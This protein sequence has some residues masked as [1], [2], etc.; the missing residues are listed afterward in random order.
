MSE[1]GSSL[2]D[3]G[4]ADKVGK[5]PEEKP[6]RVKRVVTGDVGDREG[7]NL[8]TMRVPLRTQ[9]GDASRRNPFSV[10]FAPF[11]REA[12]RFRNMPGENLAT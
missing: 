5:G 12:V 8:S 4:A 9:V 11:E 2:R 10:F 7:S 3:P 1:V 6:T